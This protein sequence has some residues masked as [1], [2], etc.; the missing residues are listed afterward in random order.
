[1]GVENEMEKESRAESRLNTP[2]AIFVFI[3]RR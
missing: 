3:K 2:T 1:M